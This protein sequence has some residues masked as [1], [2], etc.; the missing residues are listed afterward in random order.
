MAGLIEDYAL[1]GDLHTSALVS[2]TGSIDWLCLP[3]LDSDA[4][5]AALLGSGDNGH[6]T[7]SPQS[8]ILEVTRQ[9]RTDSLVLETMMRTA[10]GPCVWW[11]SCRSGRSTPSS[12]GWSKA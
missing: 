7:V 11:T 12:S 6:W 1:I 9:Y 5:F 10:G 8:E 3:R 2:R 4:A